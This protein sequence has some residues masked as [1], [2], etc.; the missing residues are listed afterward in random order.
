MSMGNISRG[1]KAAGA[2][3]WQPYH[4]HV[5]IVLKSGSLNLL[6]PSGPVQGCNG[7]AFY[8]SRT[9]VSMQIMVFLVHD[10]TQFATHVMFRRK[11]TPPFSGKLSAASIFKTAIMNMKVVGSSETLAPIYHVTCH[12]MSCYNYQVRPSNLDQEV[13]ILLCIWLIEIYNFIV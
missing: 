9:A 12:I 3:G 11:I 13:T 1:I 8:T 10:S 4:L 7:I 5:P 2:Y 6:Q